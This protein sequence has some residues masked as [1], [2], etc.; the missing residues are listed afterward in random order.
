M[1][2]NTQPDTG[3]RLWTYEEITAHTEKAIK[4][5]M[6]HARR[7]KRRHYM[8]DM[9]REW[10]YGIYINWHDLTCDCRQDADD[11]RLYALVKRVV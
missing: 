5:Y 2:D 6:K 10:A 8:A 9:Y 3:K 4:E 1:T 7:N 11:E